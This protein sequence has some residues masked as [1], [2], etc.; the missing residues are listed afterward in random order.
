M[1]FA[2]LRSARTVKESKSF[3]PKIFTTT[4]KRDGNGLQEIPGAVPQGPL[5]SKIPSSLQIVRDERTGRGLH[6][7]S[8]VQAGTLP[9]SSAVYSIVNVCV[10]ALVGTPLISGT[11][12]ISVISSQNL[13]AYCSYCSKGAALGSRLKRCSRCKQLWYCNA[14]RQVSHGLA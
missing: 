4:T 7:K 14:V 2:D 10:M 8:G 13:E 12:Q 9:Y 6:V 5:E 1:S 11:P 3:V